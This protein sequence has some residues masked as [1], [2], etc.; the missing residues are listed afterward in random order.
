[1]N[2]YQRAL[3]GRKFYVFFN[4][5]KFWEIFFPLEVKTL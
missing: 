1:M 2:K 5:G 4:F 3:R